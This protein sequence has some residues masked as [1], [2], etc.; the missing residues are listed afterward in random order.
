MGR[1]NAGQAGLGWEGEGRGR[2]G[3][4]QMGR[5]GG[6]KGQGK[7]DG[8]GGDGEAAMGP[9][10]GHGVCGAVCWQHPWGTVGCHGV[11]MAGA[12]PG[13]RMSSWLA[14]GAMQGKGRV[15]WLGCAGVA[16]RCGGG[17]R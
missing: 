15:V 16:N 2:E 9:G 5:E 8:E 17:G 4:G 7:G 1:G 10:G 14:A 6:E 3:V 12:G 11:G 13:A